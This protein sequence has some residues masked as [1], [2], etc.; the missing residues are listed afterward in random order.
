MSDAELSEIDEQIADEMDA[1]GEK[2]LRSVGER[3]RPV[4]AK[5]A[6]NGTLSAFAGG[7]TIA[8]GIS[9][10]P[11]NRRRALLQLVVGSIWI[12]VA[13][14]QRRATE[15]GEETEERDKGTAEEWKEMEEESAEEGK[16]TEEREETE[17]ESAEETTEETSIG[18]EEDAAVGGTEPVDGLGMT[19]DDIGADVTPEVDLEDAN[20]GEGSEVGRNETAFDEGT[21]ETGSEP[22]GRSSE[23]TEGPAEPGERSN[24][25][26]ESGDDALDRD[27]GT[28]VVDDENGEETDPES[29]T[30]REAEAGEDDPDVSAEATEQTPPG[31]P[32]PPTDEAGD[33]PETKLADE[34]AEA[35]DPRSADADPAR[36]DEVESG[37]ELRET[38]GEPDD[39]IDADEDDTIDV[40]EDDTTTGEVDDTSEADED[41]TSEADEDDTTGIDEDDASE[42]GTGQG[43]ASSDP[44]RDTR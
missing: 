40:G 42:S 44:H 27:S 15:E 5:H 25:S 12:G 30:E 19:G 8:R 17:K 37:E 9:N 2:R 28:E 21:V 36:T 18:G 32:E 14:V 16:E 39:P 33:I 35:V 13:M 31:D 20:R 7:V 10:L 43:G 11:R 26:R 34:P 22:E 29:F 6:R 24:E 4:I 38:T 41:D 23:A 1:E 3:L